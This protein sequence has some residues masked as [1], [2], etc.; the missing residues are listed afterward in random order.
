MLKMFINYEEGGNST[1]HQGKQLFS[2]REILRK[3]QDFL[4]IYKKNENKDFNKLYFISDFLLVTS[5][6][7]RDITCPEVL[8]IIR[9]Y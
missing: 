3:K 2:P 7:A 6:V 4:C 8:V 1:N 5:G 9:L